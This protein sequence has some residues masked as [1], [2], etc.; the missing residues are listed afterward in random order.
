MAAAV[1]ASSEGAVS[2]ELR[3]PPA[4][5]DLPS[6]EV[7]YEELSL[8]VRVSDAAAARTMPT[9][10]ETLFGAATALP[11]A[12]ARAFSRADAAA[13]PAREVRV[14]DGVS[15]VIRPATMTLLL[16]HPGAGKSTFLKALTGRLSNAKA[17]AGTVRYAGL[18][19]AALA[20]A[21]LC[22]GQLVQYVSQLDEH[23]PFLTVRESLTFV[24]ANAI[25]G[26]DAAAVAARVDEICKL[27]HL[28]AC[29][30]TI[31][32]DELARGVSGG[33]KKRVTVGEGIITAA[34]FLA[35]DEISTGLDSAVT[36]D[37]VKSLRS[38][39]REQGLGVVM[40]LLQPTP[41]TVSLFDDVIL[42]REGAVVYHGAR[43]A[44]PGYLRGLGFLLPTA[45][46]GEDNAEDLADWLSELLTFPTRRHAKDLAREGA[47]GA[48]DAAAPPLTTAAL[49]AAWRASPL[50]A[51]NLRDDGAAPPV[52]ATPAARAQYGVP[53]VH[54]AFAHA[55]SLFFR[56]VRLLTANGL[57]M[58]V[59]SRARA[60]RSPRATT[61]ARRSRR[62]Y[63]P[64]SLLP[65][66]G[67]FAS[68][69]PSSWP[70]SSARSTTRATSATASTSTGSS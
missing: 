52:L 7:R 58:F 11:R 65:R 53:Y 32:G 10:G 16:G 43:D 19:P 37:V 21:G 24:A 35:L 34:R 13:A 9:V 59:S 5:A 23:F 26:A 27:L 45:A 66:A 8:T 36:F 25:A 50:R 61:R 70:S 4:A 54:S 60:M 64:P 12:L 56:Q 48:A 1:P 67:S 20:E 63:P 68:S 39:A 42:L 33:E 22:L 38:R 47:V 6:I 2:V 40:A 30:D 3:A 15:G 57:F 41:E 69:R 46:A 62:A 55:R 44:L 18:A 49:V 29:A 17:L 31:I 51:H 14:L 28:T